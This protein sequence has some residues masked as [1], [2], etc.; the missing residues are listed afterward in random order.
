[1]LDIRK[2]KG[3]AEEAI[4]RYERYKANVGNKGWWTL[5][6][7][8]GAAD[9]SLRNALTREEYLA[10]FELVGLFNNGSLEINP[11]ELVEE[12]RAA[13]L[14]AYAPYSGYHVGAALIAANDQGWE[15]VFRGCNVENAAYGSTI[16]AE[17]GAVM[18]AVAE[19]YHHMRMI[20]VVAD[21]SKIASPC[22]SCRQM[23]AEFNLEMI[24]V[25]GSADDDEIEIEVLET[26]LPR[27]FC[28]QSL[29]D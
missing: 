13:R 23:L 20:A 7:E 10:L 16:C 22:G 24:V 1:M 17:R 8:S 18:H 27:A 19:G 9:Q 4:R 11:H 14:N 12:A 3:L 21:G 5:E 6:D 25:C 15:R 26:L 28:P 29:K 2:L